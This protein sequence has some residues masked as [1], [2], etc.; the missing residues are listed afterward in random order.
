MSR[1]PERFGNKEDD[2]AYVP[3]PRSLLPTFYQALAHI[4]TA[5]ATSSPSVN[6]IGRTGAREQSPKVIDLIASVAVEIGADQHPVSLADLRD[7]YLHA[8]PGIGKG[9]ARK[10]FNEVIICHCIN[11]PARL[12]ARRD[13]N[14]RPTWITRPVLKR[15][16]HDAY[17]LLSDEDLARFRHCVETNH[18]LIYE[19][20]FDVA[21]LTSCDEIPGKND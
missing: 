12:R 15:V 8:Y 5:P 16:E 10:N 20:A 11:M 7:A 21:A 17:M 18:P 14:G 3:V 2:L 4:M 19:A 9:I 13:K 6:R 1:M